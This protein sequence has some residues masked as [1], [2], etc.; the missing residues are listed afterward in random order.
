MK[1]GKCDTEMMVDRV[2]RNGNQETFDYKCPN[3]KCPDYGY[4]KEGAKDE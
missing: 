3:P 2:T 1:C 4:K